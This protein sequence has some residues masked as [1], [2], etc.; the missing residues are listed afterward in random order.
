MKRQKLSTKNNILYKD[1]KKRA[2]V[3][4]TVAYKSRVD[5]QAVHTQHF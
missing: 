3:E 5:S 4:M 1:K 2:G